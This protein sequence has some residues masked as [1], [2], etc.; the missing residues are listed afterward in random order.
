M[1]ARKLPVTLTRKARP[2]YRQ[3]MLYSFQTWGEKQQVAY[4]DALLRALAII[5]ENPNIGRSRDDLRPGYRAY[6][7]REHIILRVTRR[8]VSVARIVHGRADLG[9]ALR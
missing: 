3:I 6:V 8:S 4:N 7:V 5:G 2:D 1:S 9:R